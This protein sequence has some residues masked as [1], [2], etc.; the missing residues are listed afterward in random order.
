MFCRVNKKSNIKGQTQK[1]TVTLDDGDDEGLA[2]LIPDI[3]DT[4][5]LV[6][7]C[8]KIEADHLIAD[9]D[10]SN[11]ER[12]LSRSIEHRYLELMKALQFGKIASSPILLISFF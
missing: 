2:L 9:C 7:K 11:I 10:G 1:V 12:P 5:A 3:Q 6:Q 8:T 4:T